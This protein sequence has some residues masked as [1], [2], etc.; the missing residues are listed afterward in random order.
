M[1]C[2]SGLPSAVRCGVHG[3]AAA[4]GFDA[5]D[6]VCPSTGA[7]ASSA[8]TPTD[9]AAVEAS[10]RRLMRA[11]F[12]SYCVPRRACALLLAQRAVQ[13]LFGELH[14]PEFQ[15]L[16]VGLHTTIEGHADLPGTREHLWI[17]DRGFVHECVRAAGC[18]TLDHM[19][20]GAVVVTGAIEPCPI[21]EAGHVY[22]QRLA[23]PSTVGPPH[24]TFVGGLR[25]CPHV[26]D[27]NRA[28]VLVRNQDLLLGLDDLKGI[29]EIRG[30][31]Y[32]REVT[33]GLR[34]ERCPVRLVL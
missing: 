17:L 22:D 25:R 29:W 2:R 34:V 28:R 9:S 20:G 8:I 16:G 12:S 4:V 33:L 24:P 14:A 11:S 23:F 30:S 6:W 7:C 26:D 13:Q 3:L 18:I 10:E 27:A 21:V 5:A 31:W 15:E 19:Q 1:P 32:A